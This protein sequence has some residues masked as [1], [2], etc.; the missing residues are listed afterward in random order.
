M[1]VGLPPLDPAAAAASGVA[2]SSRR[3]DSFRNTVRDV[4]AVG[5]MAVPCATT[6]LP[7]WL[8]KSSSTAPSGL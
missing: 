1:V 2:A 4:V 6:R 5:S 8:P 7:Q 3:H